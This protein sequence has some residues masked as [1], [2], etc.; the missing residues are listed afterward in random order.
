MTKKLFIILTSLATT[1]LAAL[2]VSAVLVGNP[3]NGGT[4]IDITQEV[5]TI[6]CDFSDARKNKT[7]AVLFFDLES[8]AV[9]ATYRDPG[10]VEAAP[11]CI[12]KVIA[13][14]EKLEDAGL[15]GYDESRITSEVSYSPPGTMNVQIRSTKSPPTSSDSNSS[16]TGGGSQTSTDTTTDTNTNPNP[17]SDADVNSQCTS[18]LPPDW[19]TPNGDGIVNI[20]NLVLD[21]MTIGVGVLATI[22]I[23]IAGI[24]WL[25]ARDKEDQVVKAKSR[26][27][28]IV[29][30]LVVWGIMWLVLSWLLPGGII[31]EI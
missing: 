17:N 12:S 29:I 14:A 25:T 16:S 2:P 7:E 10:Q 1:L 27:F 5:Y 21:I 24:Q 4:I 18:I 26:I 9:S 22:G 11:W 28:N 13:V 19:C 23:T 31:L 3:D 20:I 8:S 15:F 30:G 6:T